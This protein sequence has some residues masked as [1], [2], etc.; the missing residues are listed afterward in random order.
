MQVGHDVVRIH[1]LQSSRANC[2]QSWLAAHARSFGVPQLSDA[3][4]PMHSIVGMRQSSDARSHVHVC[5]VARASCVV[6]EGMILDGAARCAQA[7]IINEKP[8]Q[9][10]R[11]L[12]LAGLPTAW[13]THSAESVRAP[14]LA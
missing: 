13:L 11:C 10:S 4:V 6:H 12:H 1:A 3:G 14:Y 2:V 5:V 8:H 7:C 9:L